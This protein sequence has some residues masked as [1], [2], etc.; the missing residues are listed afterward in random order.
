MTRVAVSLW[1]VCVAGCASSD[2]SHQVVDSVPAT[3]E[4]LLVPLDTV[5]LDASVLIGTTDFVDVSS[6]GDFLIA[7]YMQRT[8]HVFDAS[9]HHVRSFSTKDCNPEEG[10]R[11]SAGRFL[12]DGRMVVSTSTGHFLFDRD[13]IY[14]MLHRQRPPQVLV[15]AVNSGGIRHYDIREPL[16]PRVTNVMMGV[17]GRQIACFDH[18]VF[19]RF[20]E[21]SDGEPLWAGPTRVE[22][23]LPYYRAPQRDMGEGGNMKSRIDDLEELSLTATY[24]TGLYK[25]D[26][27][28]RMMTFD[29][30]YRSM[31]T[32]FQIVNI[33]TQ[34]SVHSETERYILATKNGLFYLQG[35]YEELASGELG[36]R[37][38]EVL[39]FVPLENS[40]NPMPA[41]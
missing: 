13:S 29:V 21:S 4:D 11:A 10:A 1:L 39:R 9:G 37:M 35:D 23:R 27:F 32:A 24:S 38:I 12:T 17:I 8:S 26:E 22:H 40:A 2:S 15:Y 3:F 18:G 41:P 6:K 14:F 16:F 7:D 33:Q 5:R 34:S 36:N 28:H 30:E 25:I 19:Y 31:A 20:P